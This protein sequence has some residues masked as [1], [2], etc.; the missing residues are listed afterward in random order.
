MA[1]WQ[2]HPEPMPNMEAIEKGEGMTPQQRS[3]TNEYRKA[4]REE[5][6]PICQ[7]CGEFR[8]PWGCRNCMGVVEFAHAQV[9][10][11]AKQMISKARSDI[12]IRRSCEA[13]FSR[14]RG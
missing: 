3:R 9:R 2:M 7:K 8:K 14:N 5:F 6:H 10:Y 11:H 1:A 13:L 12:R 4:K